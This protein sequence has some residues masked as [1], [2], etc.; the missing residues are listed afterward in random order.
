MAG[1]KGY[2][3]IEMLLASVVLCASVLTISAASTRPLKAA[4][5]NSQY[6]N[7]LSVARKQFNLLDYVGVSNLQPDQTLAGSVNKAGVEYQ[8]Q[9]D[10]QLI[11][12]SGLYSVQVDVTWIVGKRPY[13]ITIQTRLS[14]R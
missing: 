1:R 6:A 12:N 9:I 13:S 7:A 10:R 5:Q 2:T 11:E 4:K 3:L 14:G 8:W